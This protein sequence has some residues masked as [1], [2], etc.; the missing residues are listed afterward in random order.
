MKR[1]FDQD[2]LNRPLKDDEKIVDVADFIAVYRGF[3]SEGNIDHFF[4]YWDWNE[5]NGHQPQNRQQANNSPHL[6]KD[7]LGIGLDKYEHQQV[8]LHHE[9]NDFYRYM[10]TDVIEEYA[11]VCK[12]E[13]P[14]RPICMEGKIQ[15]TLPSEGYHIW[16]SEWDADFPKR[17]LAWA[18]FLND[19]E[20]GGELEFLHQSIRIKPRK[21]DMVIWP[22]Y[23]THLHRG[24]PPISNEKWIVTGWYE[25][26]TVNQE[27]L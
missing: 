13:K 12:F 6:E 20:E 21:G 9:F 15:K 25:D 22:A 26:L 18:I 19:V 1:E 16:H 23:F 3:F 27:I 2:K 17:Q 24:N 5:E 10:N 8:R 11:N 4:E 14:T 7:D